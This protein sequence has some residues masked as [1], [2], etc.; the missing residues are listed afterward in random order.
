MNLSDAIEAVG[1]FYVPGVA[2][3]YG[4]LNPDPWFQ[5][6]EE[7]EQVALQCKPEL[8]AAAAE[9]F[10]ERCR[11]LVDRFKREGTP[12]RRGTS[13]A[14]AFYSGDADRITMH[15]SRKVKQC[16]RCETKAD[17]TIQSRGE[18]DVVVVCRPCQSKG[19]A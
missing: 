9:R 17:L 4:Q 1:R 18:V 3:Y 6:H 5:A 13:I 16:F 11:E 15:R 19:T 8:T 2:K 14:D 10:V 7:L 12:P